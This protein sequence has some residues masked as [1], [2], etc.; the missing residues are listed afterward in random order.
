M[1]GGQHTVIMKPSR[2]DD[3][4]DADE[5]ILITSQVRAQFESM[6]PKRPA[7]PNR[8][9]P[10]SSS[11]L[12]PDEEIHIPELNKLKYLQSQAIFSGTKSGDEDDEFV[13]TQYYKE[14][15]SIDKQHHTTGNGFIKM[16]ME[17]SENEDDLQL[18][19]SHSTNGEFKQIIFKT[20]PATNDWIPSFENHQVGYI[21]SKPNRSE[22]C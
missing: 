14:L 4:L 8:S 6:M 21:S 2:S 12:V 15:E 9:E 5:Q 19:G 13:E 18:R 3:V 20:N 11:P 7:K 1:T 16:D 17:K 22:S 10:D